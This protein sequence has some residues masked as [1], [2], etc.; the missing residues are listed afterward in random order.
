MIELRF[1]RILMLYTIY[2]F[3]FIIQ[4]ATAY[5]ILTFTVHLLA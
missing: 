4:N 1:I 5:N 2:F 3:Y